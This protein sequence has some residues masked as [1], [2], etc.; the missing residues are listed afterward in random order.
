MIINEITKFY[1]IGIVKNAL[2]EKQ[3]IKQNW[4]PKTGE[5]SLQLN[6]SVFLAMT[7]LGRSLQICVYYLRGTLLSRLDLN[8]FGPPLARASLS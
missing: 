3:N 7:I 6:Y 5:L 2:K 4:P 1:Q 8:V